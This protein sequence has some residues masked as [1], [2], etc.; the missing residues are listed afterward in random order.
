MKSPRYHI[1]SKFNTRQI[2][3][4]KTLKRLSAYPTPT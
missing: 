2:S 1:A 4:T 3:Y